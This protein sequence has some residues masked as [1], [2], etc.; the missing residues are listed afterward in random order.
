MGVPLVWYSAAEPDSVR[1]SLWLGILILGTWAAKTLDQKMGTGDHQ[2]I[3]IDEVV[4]FG[5]SA[6]TAQNHAITLLVAFVLFRFFDIFKL[7][8]VRQLDR[9]SKN[10]SPSSKSTGQASRLTPWIGGVGVMADDVAAGL[11]TLLLVVLLQHFGIL[12]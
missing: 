10:Q 11:Q 1:L 6:W 2:S 8:P 7:P 3:V 9:W 12:P 5:I 4:G